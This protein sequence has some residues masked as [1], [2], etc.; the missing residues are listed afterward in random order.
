MTPEVPSGRLEVRDQ[1]GQVVGYFVPS[2][3]FQRLQNE[4]GQ[5]KAEVGELKA[6]AIGHPRPDD[7]PFKPLPPLTDA[8]ADALID[9][10]AS[11]A[12]TS[13]ASKRRTSSI[14]GGR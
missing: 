1:S 14:K 12:G 9:T 11:I 3:E 13:T 7:D 4:L 6:D 8:E 10:G 2:A 5:L